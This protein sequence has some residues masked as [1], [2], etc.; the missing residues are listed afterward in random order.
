M[1]ILSLFFRT[2]SITIAEGF[3]LGNVFKYQYCST[4]QQNHSTAQSSNWMLEHLIM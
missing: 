4:H 3:Q 2:F 1:F